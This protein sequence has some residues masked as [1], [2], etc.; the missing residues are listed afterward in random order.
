V[1][2]V[3][4]GRLSTGAAV[5]RVLVR[6]VCSAAPNAITVRRSV[7]RGLVAHASL[8]QAVLA[9]LRS[10]YADA[11]GADS[12]A[13]A[14]VCRGVLGALAEDHQ[15]GWLRSAAPAWHGAH[16]VFMHMCCEH[17]RMRSKVHSR[18]TE[19][20]AD[21]EP[22]VG[23]LWAQC[24]R[25]LQACVY[26]STKASKGD[27]DVEAGALRLAAHVCSGSNRSSS[28]QLSELYAAGVD[29]RLRVALAVA[30]ERARAL[31]M[32]LL[33]QLL[34]KVSD[35]Q[36]GMLQQRVAAN[37]AR[38][39]TK[40]HGFSRALECLLSGEDAK[41][42][43]DGAALQQKEQ[44]EHKE[45]LCVVVRLLP[46][47]LEPEQ[48]DESGVVSE[49]LR[50]CLRAAMRA[51][52]WPA[53]LSAVLGVGVMR[54]PRARDILLAD[55]AVSCAWR[56]VLFAATM[57]ASPSDVCVCVLGQASSALVST[58]ALGMLLE[59]SELHAIETWA[60]RT[61][62]SSSSSN[63]LYARVLAAVLSAGVLMGCR[64]QAQGCPQPLALL[65][66]V[67]SA[68]VTRVPLKVIALNYHALVPLVH[69]ESMYDSEPP[70]ALPVDAALAALRTRLLPLHPE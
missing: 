50:S 3:G 37:A 60:P 43:R 22:G 20:R 5:A 28:K 64:Q 48:Q 58:E 19:S 1:S 35:S 65:G 36:H 9:Y 2:E 21:A 6:T 18:A 57:F 59:S 68:L 54:L 4:D 11:D 53:W 27:A 10:P 67:A 26:G 23:G 40:H 15:R 55:G 69:G 46:S 62:S 24:D 63:F 34:S 16:A 49:A 47:Q 29:M 42:P 51:R 45:L 70:A 13:K 8:T 7:T 61:Q 25:V 66:Q 33:A 17:V 39:V 31:C 41:L 52:N 44:K 30:P 14:S 56:S 12:Q 32:L 38:C